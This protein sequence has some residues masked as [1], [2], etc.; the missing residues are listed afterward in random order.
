MTTR[1]ILAASTLFVVAGSA[2][3][4]TS[5][6]TRARFT[7]RSGASLWAT[8]LENDYWEYDANEPGNGA[9][10]FLGTDTTNH[11]GVSGFTTDQAFNEGGQIEFYGLLRTRGPWGQ[12]KPWA[13]AVYHLDWPPGFSA[14]TVPIRTSGGYD[15]P[16]LA[17]DTDAGRAFSASQPVAF[18]HNFYSAAGFGLTMRPVTVT[19]DSD[20][21]FVNGVNK[22]TSAM[23]RTGLRRSTS[24]PPPGSTGTSSCMSTGITWPRSRA[25]PP[26]N[27]APA[28]RT[29]PESTTF[30]AAGCWGTRSG[31]RL[32]GAKAWRPRLG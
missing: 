5:L 31:A 18:M 20:V 14:V 7:D 9:N 26:T 27:E 24:T 2:A 4:Q 3:A 10:D 15:I 19:L 28:G 12:V 32:R 16:A 22:N 11:F 13:G 1:C 17:T 23:T 8:F 6:Q 21:H 30:K 25:L 29:Q